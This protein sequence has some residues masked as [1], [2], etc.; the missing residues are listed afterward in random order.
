[1]NKQ[2]W[3]KAVAA[4]LGQPDDLV[5]PILETGLEEIYLAMK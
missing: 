2:E 5:A 1:M 3:I 4:R